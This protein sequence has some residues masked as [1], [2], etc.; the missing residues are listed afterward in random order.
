MERVREEDAIIKDYEEQF[1]DDKREIEA[2]EQEHEAEAIKPVFQF[3]VIENKQPVPG[4]NAKASAKTIKSVTGSVTRSRA[5]QSIPTKRSTGDER[6]TQSVTKRS[7]SGEHKSSKSGKG[8]KSSSEEEKKGSSTTSSDKDD[9][10][11]VFADVKK[12]IYIYFCYY[13]YYYL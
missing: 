12:C 8:G 7:S 1:E 4:R 9:E 13:Y 11:K 2:K 10:N 5:V 6:K 3:D